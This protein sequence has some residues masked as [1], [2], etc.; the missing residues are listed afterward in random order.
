MLKDGF[1][2][3]SF[4]PVEVSAVRLEVKLQPGFSGGVLEW[5]M[6]P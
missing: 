5:R 2:R 6:L 3:L 4:K 1:N